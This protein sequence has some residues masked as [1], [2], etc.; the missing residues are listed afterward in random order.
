MG[1]RIHLWNLSWRRHTMLEPE[2]VCLIF[3]NVAV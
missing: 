1:P 3:E 2:G